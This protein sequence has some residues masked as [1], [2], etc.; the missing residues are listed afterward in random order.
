MAGCPSQTIF[1]AP[2][3]YP[4]PPSDLRRFLRRRGRCLDLHHRRLLRGRTLPKPR[5]KQSRPGRSNTSKATITGWGW[6]GMVA[7]HRASGT[8]EGGGQGKAKYTT[9]RHLSPL[10]SST[11][12]KKWNASGK[13]RLVCPARLV[14]LIAHKN[15]A[16]THTSGHERQHH[17][18]RHNGQHRDNKRKNKRR[19]QAEPNPSRGR[20]TSKTPALPLLDGPTR[21]RATKVC[22][23]LSTSDL[24]RKALFGHEFFV[25]PTAASRCASEDDTNQPRQ[26]KNNN[27]RE[28]DGTSPT[29]I[30]SGCIARILSPPTMEPRRPS[31]LHPYPT[32]QHQ[33]VCGL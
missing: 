13:G 24:T 26:K 21:F 8:A 1:T 30:H 14:L 17:A 11:R 19:Q 29:G 12:K 31:T 10:H 32:E 28:Q 23:V 20:S 4:C 33:R 25:Q 16:Y 27:R 5:A 15:R 7:T 22:T 6:G 9:E 18:C 3:G 2:S